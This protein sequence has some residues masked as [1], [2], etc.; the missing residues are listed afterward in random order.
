[1]GVVT[2]STATAQATTGASARARVRRKSLRRQR[3]LIGWLFSLPAIC[4][5]L[6]TKY[7]PVLTSVQ[8][9]LYHW[10]IVNP[11]GVFTGLRNYLD[12]L[13]NP[14]V[15][16]SWEN[17]ILLFLFGLLLGFWVPIVQAILLDE[18]RR[19]QKVLQVLILVP[20]IIPTVA[21][22]VIWKWILNPTQV[23][24]LNGVLGLFHLGPVGWL[25]N[26]NIAKISLML[27]GLL[28]GGLGVYIYLSAIRAISTEI[29]E[30]AGID[31]AGPWHKLRFILVPSLIPTIKIMFILSLAGIFQLFDQVFFMTYGGP[32]NSTYVLAL[33]IYRDAF[34]VEHMGHAAALTV[35][36]F[37]VTAILV[38]IQL[39][40]SR[41]EPST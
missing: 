15:Q 32:A 21:G 17:N 3:Q 24:L 7:L 36:L 34:Q 41:G 16:L 20:L 5:F 29:Y 40:L 4:A 19:G 11:P 28:G 18:T 12:V 26:P 10:N 33:N 30:A 38:A 35:F 13:G 9:S 14:L 27:P 1:M 2:P 23:G 39:R 22:Y 8:M 6:Y 25:T 37:V 31:G